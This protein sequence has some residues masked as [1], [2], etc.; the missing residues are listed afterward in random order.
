MP[1]SV[2]LFCLLYKFVLY[3]LM[4]QTVFSLPETGF[5]GEII[6]NSQ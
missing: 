5:F 2:T 4:V 3:Q 1:E 6:Q